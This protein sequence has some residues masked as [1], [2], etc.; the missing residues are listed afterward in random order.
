[1]TDSLK[2]WIL[3][4]ESGRQWLNKLSAPIT[5]MQFTSYLK[6]YCKA[7]KKTPD[8]LINLKM[9]GLKNVGTAKEWQAENLLET[10]FSKSKLS[11]SAK[12]NLRNAV[13]SFYKHN[14]RDLQK[15]TASNVKDE[16]PES[17][18]RNP[19][20]EDL[21][22]LE[23]KAHLAKD[24][25]LI[26]FIAS[27]SCRVGTV[28]LLKWE[29]LKPTENV[30]VPFSLEI[31]SSR[32]KGSGVGKYKGLKQITFVHKY[33]YEKLEAYKKEA[34]LLGY[35]L[36][37]ESP[38]FIAYRQKGEIQQLSDK[39]I[40]ALFTNLSLMAFE[41]LET[42][43]FSPHDLREFFQSSLE[44]SG[45][46]ENLICP[47]M[48][49]KA[50]GISQSYSSHNYKE[51]MEKYETALPYLIPQTVEKVKA[52]LEETK[53][54]QQV[55]IESMKAEHKKEKEEQNKKIE[56]LE[57]HFE[58]KLAETMRKAIDFI[59]EAQKEAN[60]KPKSRE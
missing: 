14:R 9:E 2:S 7:V 50:K 27:T 12:L 43:R 11:K 15:Q 35:D 53:T 56:E 39:A 25:A 46:Q 38:L 41:D 17:K 42:K 26:W 51:L 34:K 16:T 23:D 4:F 22:A 45:M 21:K 31:E 48:A 3:S 36:K 28:V 52:E 33:A 47:I 44:S 58:A 59:N 19:S 29:D 20:L 32:L 8:E 60:K 30:N 1:M 49:H 18:K 57:D 6:Q 40:N 54:E 24:K 55:Q 10:F 13:F 5:K 37:P